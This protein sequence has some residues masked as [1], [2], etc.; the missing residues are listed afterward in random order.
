M[1]RPGSGFFEPAALLSLFSALLYAAAALLTRRLGGTELG[2]VMT[3]YQNIVFLAGAALVAA[4]LTYGGVH[5]GSHPSLD[6]LV[7]PWVLPPT[8]DLLLMGSCGVISTIGTLLLTHAY[9]VAEVN[10]IGP[11]E[12][13]GILWGPMWGFLIFSEVP[14]PTTIVGATLIVISGLVALQPARKAKATPYSDTRTSELVGT[15]RNIAL[16]S[17]QQEFQNSLHIDQLC[18]LG[19]VIALGAGRYELTGEGKAIL[20]KESSAFAT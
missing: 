18:D 20:K 4:G 15:L 17:P 16:H 9:R 1:L 11:F 12:Y 2:S 8:A 5:H 19:Y 10:R 13:T 7:R 3:F 14:R 6:F